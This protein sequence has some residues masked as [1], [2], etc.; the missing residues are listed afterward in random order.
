MMK[1]WICL[2]LCMLLP[3]STAAAQENEIEI[4]LGKTILVNGVAR[5][6]CNVFTVGSH[7]L[8]IKL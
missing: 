4:S 8:S 1:T 5:K 2:L 7:I 6:N 3:L